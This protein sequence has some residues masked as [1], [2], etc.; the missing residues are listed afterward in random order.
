MVVELAQKIAGNFSLVDID[1]FDELFSRDLW[2]LHMD[3]GGAPEI[4]AKPVTTP[5]PTYDMAPSR[6]AVFDDL[7]WATL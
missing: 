7:D 3:A 1:G 5:A 6:S 4:I 2:Q